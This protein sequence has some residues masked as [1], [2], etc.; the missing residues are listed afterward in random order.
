MSYQI[1]LKDIR[2]YIEKFQNHPELNVDEVKK[3]MSYEDIGYLIKKTSEE[4]VMLYLCAADEKYFFNSF[5][6]DK[7]LN[8]IY[9]TPDSSN[10][11]FGIQENISA[12]HMII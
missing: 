1:I 5:L 12:I 11:S 4:W 10:L 7:K 2:A 8:D 6:I 3:W 9:S